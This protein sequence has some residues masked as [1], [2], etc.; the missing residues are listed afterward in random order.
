MMWLKFL[1]FLRLFDATGYLIRIVLNMVWDMKIFIMILFIVQMGF[2]EAFLRLSEQ[3]GDAAFL[4]NFGFAFIYAF[5]LTIGDNDTS[6]FADI[7]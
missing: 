3:S 6:A 2:G 1:Y 5:R 7:S 4:E